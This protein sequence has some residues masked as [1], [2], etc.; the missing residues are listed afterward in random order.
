MEEEDTCELEFFKISLS[1]DTQTCS[2]LL[3]SMSNTN[4]FKNLSIHVVRVIPKL[5]LSHISVITNNDCSK[6]LHAILSDTITITGVDTLLSFIKK[7]SGVITSAVKISSSISQYDADVAEYTCNIFPDEISY[8]THLDVNDIVV[9]LKKGV[10]S[11]LAGV[12]KQMLTTETQEDDFTSLL[13]NHF[14]NYEWV[15]DLS[16]KQTG[17]V[18][19]LHCVEEGFVSESQRMEFAHMLKLQ[20][21]PEE[22]LS[23]AANLLKLYSFID[24]K[25]SS[26]GTVTILGANLSLGDIL[27]RWGTPNSYVTTDFNEIQFLCSECF[28][29]D[30]SLVLSGKN[31]AI[32]APKVIVKSDLFRCQ[33]HIDLS[34]R[35]GKSFNSTCARHGKTT[36]CEGPGAPGINGEDG[37][38]GE[39]GGNLTICADEIQNSEL[40]SITSDGGNGGSGQ[41]GGNGQDGKSTP[42]CS[43]D[44]STFKDGFVNFFICSF[45]KNNSF[46][47]IAF[48]K[49]C[50]DVQIE[51]D[52]YGSYAYGI[53]KHGVKL[54]FSNVSTFSNYGFIF[55]KGKNGNSANGGDAG[56]GGRPGGGG[57]SGKLCIMKKNGRETND[58][59]NI[60]IISCKSGRDGE[61]GKSGKAGKKELAKSRMD[62]LVVDGFIKGPL[63]YSGF[64]EAKAYKNSPNSLPRGWYYL[65]PSVAQCFDPSFK[66]G[67]IEFFNSFRNNFCL[68]INNKTARDGMQKKESEVIKATPSRQI[69][70]AQVLTMHQM[71]SNSFLEVISNSSFIQFLEAIQ[72]DVQENLQELETKSHKHQHKEIKKLDISSDQ[73]SNDFLCISITKLKYQTVKSEDKVRMALEKA[74]KNSLV[75]SL[76]LSHETPVKQT[77]TKLMDLVQKQLTLQLEKTPIHHTTCISIFKLM[78][79]IFSPE[80]LV[81]LDQSI[82]VDDILEILK[83]AQKVVVVAASQYPEFSGFLIEIREIIKP[84][85][86]L[87]VLC[88]AHE[89][90]LKNYKISDSD[91][92]QQCVCAY[93]QMAYH[94]TIEDVNESFKACFPEQEKPN[95]APY[96][97]PIPE[98]CTTCQIALPFH[99]D[100]ISALEIL[101]VF[102]NETNE[103]RQGKFCLPDLI[104]AIEREYEAC[105]YTISEPDLMFIL[106]YLQDK[107]DQL[108]LHRSYLDDLFCDD[109]ISKIE[110][111][112]QY[113]GGIILYK[114]EGHT[115][116]DVNYNFQN[117]FV[118]VTAKNI[119]VKIDL[120]SYEVTIDGKLYRDSKSL[121]VCKFDIV[122]LWQNFETSFLSSEQPVN[123]EKVEDITSNFSQND[124]KHEVTQVLKLASEAQNVPFSIFS[125]FAPS[126][127]IEQL[128]MYTVQN[129]YFD[130]HT[131]FVIEFKK[132]VANLSQCC[133]KSLYFIFYSKF[134]QTVMPMTDNFQVSILN[135]L[136]S[137]QHIFI[138]EALC[139]LVNYQTTAQAGIDDASFIVD[140]LIDNNIINSVGMFLQT[141]TLAN[142]KM[143]CQAHGIDEIFLTKVFNMQ[144][145]ISQ[146]ADKEIPYWNHKLKEI[147]LRILFDNIIEDEEIF[148][149]ILIHICQ[150]QRV[151]DEIKVFR[152]VEMVCH[153]CRGC[154]FKDQLLELFSKCSSREW[155][156]STVESQIQSYIEDGNS[157]N[158]IPPLCQAL[159]DLQSLDWESQINCEKTAAEIIESIKVQL[160]QTEQ[161]LLSELD[162][163]VE[164]VEQIKELEGFKSQ[165]LLEEDIEA[166][167]D[168]LE[169]EPIKMFSKY[170][171]KLWA[172][173]FKNLKISDKNSCITEAFAVIRR[174]ITLFY[175]T[176]KNI[177]GIVPRDTQM[178]ASLLFFQKLSAQGQAQGTK[179]MQQISTGEGKTMILCMVAI[180]KALLGENVDIVTSS[181]VLATRDADR[182]KPLYELF[183]IT[184]SHCCH[185]S[186]D[187]RQKAYHSS[188]MY[189][190]IGSFQRD[191]LETDFYDRA[192]RTNRTYHNVFIDEVD[193]MLIDKGESMLY[194]PHALPNMNHLDQMYLEIWS[195]VNSNDFL[196]LESD[197]EQLYFTLKHKWFGCIAPN[198]FTAISGVSIK[199][200]SEIFNNLVKLGVIAKEDHSLLIKDIDIIMNH[201]DS[202]I[203]ED[204]VR[205]EIIMIIQEHLQAAPL[206]KTIPQML[207]P[208]I[209]K[210]LKS[211]IH[212]AVCAK[213]FRA[214]HEYIIDIDHRESAS[215]RYPKIVIMDNET[216]VE[217]ESSEWSNGLHQFLQLKHN[218]RL[219]TESLKA[220]YMSNI[221]FFTRYYINVLGVTGTM[222]SVEECSLFKKFYE[223]ILI[224]EV[225]TNKPS[226]LKIGPSLCCS[227]RTSWEEAVFTD[228]QE[229]VEANRVI[230][231]ICENVDSARNVSQIVNSKKP[232]W[233]VILY[234]SSRQEKLEETPCFSPGHVIIATNLAG[235]G[236]DIKLSDEVKERG[237]LHV[238][239]TYLPPNVRVELQAYGR[240]AR[241]GEPGSCTIIFYSKEEELSYAI[242]KRDLAEAQ[243]VSEIEKDYFQNICFQ[244]RLFHSFSNIY[245]QVKSKYD[246]IKLEQRIMLDYCLDCWAFFLDYFTD[247]IEAIPKQST[248][249]AERMKLSISDHFNVQVQ[250]KWQVLICKPLLDINLSP[251]R[252]IQLGHMYMRREVKVGKKF[253][254]CKGTTDYDLALRCYEK[255]K[256]CGDPFA[257]YYSAAAQL[258]ASF[259]GKNTTLDEGKSERRA[260]KQELYKIVPIFQNKIQQCQSQITQLQVTNRNQD[261]TLTGNM[262]YFMEQ[263][264]HEI[265]IY[266]QFVCSMQDILGKEIMP[267]MFEHAD[268]GRDGAEVV[269]NIIRQGFSLKSR[270]AKSYTDRLENMF[271]HSNSYLIYEAKIIERIKS[272]ENK[273]VER[274]DLAGAVPDKEQFWTLLKNKNII[275]REVKNDPTGS[276]EIE[277][278][279]QEKVQ[280]ESVPDENQGKEESSQQQNI[281]GYWN[282]EIEDINEVQ[283]ECWDSIDIHSFDWIKGLEREGKEEILSQLKDNKIITNSGQ[284]VDLNLAK[285]LNISL[286]IS[287]VQHYKAIK[288][289]LW[290]H[291]IYRYMLDHLNECTVIEA[292]EISG[293]ESCEELTAQKSIADVLSALCEDIN[294]SDKIIN[295]QISIHLKTH[296]DS[297]VVA[298]SEESNKKF[299]D[300]IESINLRLTDVSGTG[301]TAFINAVIQ[302]ARCDYITSSFSE[303]EAVKSLVEKSHPH[304]ELIGMANWNSE[305]ADEALQ[306]VNTTC[307]S[308]IGLLTVFVSSSNW[309]LKYRI[310]SD[311]RF[312]SDKQAT[313]WLKGNKFWSIMQQ[314]EF[315]KSSYQIED[316][317]DVDFEKDIPM[318]TMS[319]LKVL[320]ELHIV[321]QTKPTKKYRI[322]KSIEKIESILQ[323]SDCFSDEDRV[324]VS[325]FLTF[326]LE[327]DFKTLCGSPRSLASNQSHVLYDDLCLY[328]VIKNFKVKGTKAEMERKCEEL[329]IEDSY[330]IQDIGKFIFGSIPF[331][332][333]ETVLNRYLQSKKVQ[334]LTHEEFTKLYDYLSSRNVVDQIIC[335]GK[336]QYK[337]TAN[338][339][340]KISCNFL[341]EDQITELKKYVVLMLQLRKNSFFILNTLQDKQSNLLERETPEIS[342]RSLDDVIEDS[343]R[344]NRDV[345]CSFSDNQCEFIV[346]LGEQ[347]WS[348]KTIT[349]GI[350]VIAIGLAQIILGA[351]LLVSTVGVGS[352]LCNGLIDEGVSDFMF[353]IQGLARGH[354]NWSQYWQHKK[355]SLIITVATAG[356]GA[357]FVR[358]TKA[359]TYAYKALKNASKEALKNTAEL[360]GKSYAKIMAKQVCKKLSNTVAGAVADVGIGIAC[361][362]VVEGLSQSIDSV[363]QAIVD[364]FDTMTRDDSFITKV[365]C[366]F[367]NEENSEVAQQHLKQLFTL[368]MQQNTFLEILDNIESAS[369]KG[370]KIGTRAH[371]SVAEQYTMVGKNV[372]GKGVVKALG[373]VSQFNLLVTKPVKI[374][375]VKRKMA[376]LKEK[377]INELERHH[378]Q[379]PE[380]QK[381]PQE[382]R[383]KILAE[384]LK[385]M[386]EILRDEISQR[387]KVIVST[388]L[389]IIGQQLKKHITALG[390]EFR[391]HKFKGHMDMKKLKENEKKLLAAKS[392]K[393]RSVVKDYE[394]KLSKLMS[395]TRNPKVYAALI[396]HHNAELGPGFAI[397][398]LE[399]KIGRPIKL[400]SEDGAT[401][402]N[403]QNSLVKGDP[404]VITFTPATESQPGHFYVGG[405]SFSV[406]HHGNDCLIHAVMK[407][408]GSSE[409]STSEVRKY[410]ANCCINDKYDARPHDRNSKG[411][412]REPHP[413]YSNIR[414][415]IASNYV[416]IGLT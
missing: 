113:I 402:M 20:S 81:L 224:V 281:V 341:T 331:H 282:P 111:L 257:C 144:K 68:T 17:I 316:L 238:C 383:D 329:R 391:V 231:L 377:L 330:V 291:S 203:P 67:E 303:A 24:K 261:Q 363:S 29:I 140:E 1:S 165:I 15:K 359:S 162:R 266:Q 43:D 71:L 163:I 200:S 109:L 117:N 188:V 23:I 403:A 47:I 46:D 385:Q 157:V 270:I 249:E 112:N 186:T 99:S 211:W 21:L 278:S 184:V 217:Q 198:A 376:I 7:Y 158:D 369:Q 299:M 27:G 382:T 401:L 97:K 205:N 246:D 415:G 172:K 283:L 137:M 240:A 119:K 396:E 11:K 123:T 315:I 368:V 226:R 192:I 136:E 41:D 328:A 378:C 256:V 108:L 296:T 187:K 323:S 268:W 280:S 6:E 260:L 367:D 2:N 80:M 152:F 387:G 334:K 343:N 307:S 267:T 120:Q 76:K 358:G 45:W 317:S 75:S 342:L 129:Y 70:L 101:M 275:T 107:L 370:L 399:T 33:Y 247:S 350:S 156:F 87:L 222:G 171:I 116:E 133:D 35:D 206:I 233:N 285:P 287:Q 216:G 130:E 228:I 409:Y 150:M 190:D 50:N 53:T 395:R 4:R 189:G 360:T 304:T 37:E 319:Q 30:A 31:I 379:I 239:L 318:I 338:V 78:K 74:S 175:E 309:P 77:Y 388:G 390:K 290:N 160:P 114:E 413:C 242:Q 337:E 19:F 273:Q 371:G 411:I 64:I 199:K 148:N 131:D 300:A 122:A 121:L 302:H 62:Y 397:P 38:V 286:K 138:S 36:S 63:R 407:S 406:D 48:A 83:R 124:C 176:E 3:T 293:I 364:S 289:T 353:G 333:D 332:F 386:K 245:D 195:L 181:S 243:R 227:C 126:Q 90:I 215:D 139:T 322:C 89:N 305:M 259:H 166:Q 28:Y 26:K 66:K 59:H 194:L 220:V 69:D 115:I 361:E 311:E 393:D 241:N 147:Q 295:P 335:A 39:S 91:F 312:T 320:E 223:E 56:K 159:K 58:D 102:I 169:S 255:A 95:L 340:R 412:K 57:K 398:A 32:I 132:R 394:K 229:K 408:S 161:Y 92:Q 177:R 258:N 202:F 212:S 416:Q 191:I 88:L 49:C 170:H 294:S 106:T 93:T 252:F 214:N 151:Y 104:Q 25:D 336:E 14:T 141:T 12:A 79:D 230:L 73:E 381:I 118:Q 263:K 253:V 277:E 310:V 84:K 327:V 185:D 298:V 155:I 204:F 324:Q 54:L 197:Q 201:A 271:L 196:G 149:Q 127:W 297:S 237:G 183:G 167:S 60:V 221:S 18:R 392:E 288:D 180:Y 301:L 178:V 207:H 193:S 254:K 356:I 306:C 384:E 276:H 105:R 40:L 179:L 146:L 354:C 362:R 400:V 209:K 308:K 248:S 9:A 366:F 103:S 225:P 168:K 405:Q 85:Y 218:L 52:T 236:T 346:N 373:Y 100:V 279:S 410:I 314:Q 134:L 251:N 234:C 143:F 292:N 86:E 65:K 110:E 321:C 372:K 135:V 82:H 404:L 208:F 374:G 128:I 347:L 326:K 284:L 244:E 213:Y 125:F 265:Q 389:N 164:L 344:E 272:L 414:S 232:E 16:L 325:H 219:S 10:L 145:C 375:L 13:K 274:S 339:I 182:Q 348:W 61:A 380:K 8:A 5:L 142:I 262:Q 55:S 365:N 357:Y 42:S 94:K 22:K 72:H 235:R 174:G 51:S 355:L 349:T 210:S 351:V 173:T 153:H 269:F 264:N 250:E 154:V 313:L 44:F 34:G 98:F 352:V 345:L 96:K